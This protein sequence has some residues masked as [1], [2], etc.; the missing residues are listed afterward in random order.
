MLVKP[1]NHGVTATVLMDCC[2]SGTV[3]D[4]PY[5]FGAD[6]RTMTREAGFNMDVVTEAARK[7]K[8]TDAELAAARK[9][10]NKAKREQDKAEQKRADRREQPDNIVCGPKLAPNGQPVLPTRPAQKPPRHSSADPSSHPKKDEQAPPV[11][12]QQ[13]C[14][15]L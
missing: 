6:D 12:P 2:H 9:E 13:C 5:K 14:V 4:L 11:P 15:I 1:M 8:P 7:E 3:L 10:R